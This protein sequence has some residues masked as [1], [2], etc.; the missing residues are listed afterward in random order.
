MFKLL[1]IDIYKSEQKV[2]EMLDNLKRIQQHN[3]EDLKRKGFVK[4]IGFLA[5][6]SKI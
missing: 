2:K 1:K 6:Q 4:N 3:D 5:C